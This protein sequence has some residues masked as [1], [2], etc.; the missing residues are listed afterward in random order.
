MIDF[1]KWQKTV[2]LKVTTHPL[3]GGNPVGTFKIPK[4]LIDKYSMFYTDRKTYSAEDFNSIYNKVH[5]YIKQHSEYGTFVLQTHNTKYPQ[6]IHFRN[7]RHDV[8]K[9]IAIVRVN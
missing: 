9:A 8:G 7:L 1:S 5:N 6:V 3:D 2:E 4:K